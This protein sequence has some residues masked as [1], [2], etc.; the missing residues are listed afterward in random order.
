MVNVTLIFK[1]LNVFCLQP[2]VSSDAIQTWEKISSITSTLAQNLSEQ[3]R[4]LLEPTQTSRLK[5][6]YKS[7]K[8][9]NM[10]KV[11]PYIAS[12][13]RKDKIWLRRTK[14][15]KREYQI[16]LAIDDSSS[17][18]DVNAKE[19]AFESIAL[20]SRALM[21]LESGQ[22]SIL[23][24]GERT[25]ILHKLTDTFTEKSGSKLL[26]TFQFKQPN[27][28]IA[29]LVNFVT[30]ML[31]SSVSRSNVLNA[32]LLVIISDGLGVFS[33]GETRIHQAIR[34]AR[35]SNVFIVF[36][37]IDNPT[38]KYSILDVR[39]PFFNES[40]HVVEIKPYMDLFPF[41]FYIILKDTNSLPNVLSDA[42]RQWF[43]MVSHNDK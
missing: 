11:I 37:I 20:I 3:L 1:L 33:E 9:I 13:F 24:F 2:P 39:M 28:C 32:K 25:D 26:Q 22:L 41:P 4:L 38:N 27:T 7:G 18:N 42:L 15:S 40:G 10:R 14:P 6:D 43:E 5:G 35:L 12:Q 31:E 30:E 17:M 19:L 8:R 23:S 21:L 29:A 36:I 34:R 16:V